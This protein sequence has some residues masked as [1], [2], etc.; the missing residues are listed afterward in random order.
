MK[1]HV[2]FSS[3][4][5]QA[6]C[7]T[8]HPATFL[9]AVIMILVW[10]ATGPFFQYSDTWQLVINTSTTIVTFLMVF[11]IQS[12]Q[13]RD[14]IAIHVKLDE[15]IR[16]VKDARNSVINME[17]LED[18]DL[19]KYAAEYQEL[20]LKDSQVVAEPSSGRSPLCAGDG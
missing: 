1:I 17:N 13:N 12:S 4:A 14:T 19:R 20:A 16:A 10:G 6:A 7:L 5:R 11:L 3:L 15:L 2:A 9:T 18:E 8:G